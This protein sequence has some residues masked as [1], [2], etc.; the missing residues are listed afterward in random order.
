MLIALSSSLWNKNIYFKD[1][2]TGGLF[3]INKYSDYLPVNI[4]HIHYASA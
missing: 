2:V 1:S 4:S 3:S